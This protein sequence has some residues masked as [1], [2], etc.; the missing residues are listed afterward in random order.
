MATIRAAAAITWSA[1]E[2]SF[3]TLAMSLVVAS[4]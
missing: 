4:R 3:S 1:V 2:L